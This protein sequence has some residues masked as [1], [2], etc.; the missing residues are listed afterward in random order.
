MAC[1]RACVAA[2]LL[3]VSAPTIAAA[4]AGPVPFQ[5][6]KTRADLKR[7]VGSAVASKRSVMVWVRADWALSALE[8]ERRTWAD[9]AVAEATG[10]FLLLRADVTHFDS[11][12][13]L[14]LAALD[15]S[16][17]PAVLFYGIDGTEQRNFRVLGF[18]KATAFAAM[19]RAAG[20]K[21]PGNTK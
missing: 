17:T 12:D 15:L 11:E 7:E 4:P 19:I 6:I 1:S 10:G 2:L 21:A 16:G 8:M 13:K 5:P 14:L 20:A 3:C 18:M 9:P